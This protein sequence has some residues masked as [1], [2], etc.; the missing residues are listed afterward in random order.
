MCLRKRHLIRHGNKLMA[1]ITKI[2]TSTYSLILTPNHRKPQQSE[3]ESHKRLTSTRW[4]DPVN[5]ISVHGVHVCFEFRPIHDIQ[6]FLDVFA[7]YIE[8][9]FCVLTGGKTD[10]IGCFDELRELFFA[11]FYSFCNDAPTRWCFEDPVS[12]SYN[13]IANGGEIVEGVYGMRG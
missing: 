10:W 4:D 11:M 6:H 2:M 8:D 9:L 3:K 5:A 12:E 1:R 7:E 13:L